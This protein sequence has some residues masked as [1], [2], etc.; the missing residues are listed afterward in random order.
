M[1]RFRMGILGT[2][3][4][5]FRRFLPALKKSENWEYGGVASRS[6]EKTGK[7][8]KSFGG[9]GYGSYE[10]LISDAAIDAV[11]LPL[12]PALHFEWAK[13]AL[14]QGKH[15]FLE[16]PAAT[17]LSE[18]EQLVEIA[19]AK[20]LALRENYMFTEHPQLKEILDI[21]QKETIGELR[22]IRIAFGFPRRQGQD[23][24]YEKSLGGGALLDCGGYTVK[25]AS[26]LLGNTVKCCYSNLT[27]DLY[28]DVDL[29]GSAVFENS[30]KQVAQLSFGMDN[31]YKCELEIWGQKGSIKSSRIFTAPADMPINIELEIAGQK[32]IREI[33]AR[34]QFYGSL[35]RFEQCIQKE[36][37][38]NREYHELLLQG[39]LIEEIQKNS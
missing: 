3:E 37:A 35:L 16:K 26:L 23:F 9:K 18:I 36:S 38:R 4:I 31:S 29:Y 20:G 11:Y 10:E 21:L 12:P 34:D 14:E 19:S 33:S 7:F 15:V 1:R 8:T 27:Q 6:L 25:L 24:R 39:K 2:S 17:S 5:A 30:Q 13:K 28:S 22:L 32:E